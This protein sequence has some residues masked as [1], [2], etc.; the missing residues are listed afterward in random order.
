[1]LSPVFVREVPGR[2]WGDIRRELSCSTGLT[3]EKAAS[4]LPVR[5]KALI[6]DSGSRKGSLV[7][8]G[9]SRCGTSPGGVLGGLL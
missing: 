3:G 5:E 7:P 2:C 1:M 9:R 4:K 6:G 8:A